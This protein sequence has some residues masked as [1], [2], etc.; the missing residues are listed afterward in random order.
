MLEPALLA[1]LERIARRSRR[2]TAQVIREAMEEYVAKVGE[3]GEP[4]LPNFVGIGSGPGDVAG[5]DE[6]ILREELPWRPS[7]TPAS[8]TP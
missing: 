6:S 8:S 2:P 4:S 1:E 5:R 3:A 7:S